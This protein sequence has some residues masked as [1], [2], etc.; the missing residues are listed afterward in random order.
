MAPIPTPHCRLGLCCPLSPHGL[1]KQR[2]LHL[3][4]ALIPCQVL[5]FKAPS[6]HMIAQVCSDKDSLTKEA[7][8]GRPHPFPL[9][10]LAPKRPYCQEGISFSNLQMETYGW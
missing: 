5:S 9:L 4:L 3:H 6:L 8:G 1:T 2:A 10:G 7:S